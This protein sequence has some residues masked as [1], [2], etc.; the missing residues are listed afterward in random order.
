MANPALPAGGAFFM[1][2]QF[3]FSPR[4]RVPERDAGDK[5][6]WRVFTL[7]GWHGLSELLAQLN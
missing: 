2:A 6:G 1:P 3:C 4:L 5:T 7:R